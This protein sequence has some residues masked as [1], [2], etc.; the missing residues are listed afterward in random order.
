MVNC[1]SILVW[2]HVFF[3]TIWLYYYQNGTCRPA[4]RPVH[5]RTITPRCQWLEVHGNH[6]ERIKGLIYWQKVPLFLYWS[7][8]PVM[9]NSNTPLFTILSIRQGI[10][11]NKEQLKSYFDKDMTLAT[12]NESINIEDHISQ[13]TSHTLV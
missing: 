8:N 6:L 4:C 2:N 1:S 5:T 13:N 9:D 3:I 10:Y 7:R 11:T 12:E